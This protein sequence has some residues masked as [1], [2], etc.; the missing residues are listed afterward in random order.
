MHMIISSLMLTFV[1]FLLFFLIFRI[2]LFYFDNEFE[3]FF[4]YL[5]FY[6]VEICIFFLFSNV[7]FFF[8]M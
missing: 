4:I 2:Q 1:K 3:E 6:W 7:T 8:T 5:I